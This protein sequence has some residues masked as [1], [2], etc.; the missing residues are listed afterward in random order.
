MLLN[1]NFRN[2]YPCE[3][4]H[5]IEVDCSLADASIL[6]L[7]QSSRE[8]RNVLSHVSVFL[9]NVRGVRDRAFPMAT[10]LQLVADGGGP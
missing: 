7:F 4:C 5:G 3:F 9:V 10:S 8:G 2:F 6:R 1:Q